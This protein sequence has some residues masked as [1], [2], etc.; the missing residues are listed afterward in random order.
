MD[1]ESAGFPV[2]RRILGNQEDEEEDGMGDGHEVVEKRATSTT[3]FIEEEDMDLLGKGKANNAFAHSPPDQVVEE[4]VRLSRMIK[5]AEVQ[6]TANIEEVLSSHVDQGKPLEVTH[7]VSLSD[8]RKSLQKWAPSAEK[9]Y[10]N[11]VESKRAFRPVKQHELP[12]GCQVVPCKGV[13]TVKPDGKGFRRKT[14]FVACGNHL[15]EG[16]L[17]GS[18]F[19]VY[20]AGLD[21]TSLRTM[22]AYKSKKRS[23]H[24]GVTDIRQAFVLAPWIGKPVA[25]RPPSLAVDLGLAEPDD[26]WLVL[27]SIYGLRESPAAWAAY[28]DGQLKA[29]RW[30]ARLENEEV[31]LRLEQLVSDNQVWRIVRAD[32]KE[33]E[34]LGFLLVYIDD[35]MV[36]GLEPAMRSFFQWLSNTWEC[37]D[38]SVLTEEHPLKFLGMELHLVDGGVE[39]CQEGF[40]RELLRSHQHD[41][42][43]SKTQGPKELM[44]MSAE[45][46]A[47]MLEG[48]P[49][50]DEAKEHLVKD[51]QRR[52]GELLWL[53]SR[54]RPDIQYA[55]AVMSSRITRCPEAVVTIGQ[56]ILDYLNETIHDRI[57][58]A[59]DQEEPQLLQAYTDSSFAPSS[60]KSHGSVAIFYGTCPLA[61]RSSRQPLVSLSTAETELME[62]VEGTVM[63]Y[64]TKCLL[65]ELLGKPLV[66]HLHIDNSAAI[67][68][69]TTAAGSWRTR[70]LRLRA[71]WVKEKMQLKEVSIKHEP[72]VT[73]RADLGTK[74][75]S[76]DRLAQLKE[77]WSVK[78]RRP[79]LVSSLKVMNVKPW[80]KALLF[81]SQVSETL[82]MKE[83]IRAEVPWDLYVVVIILAIAVIGL[84]EGLKHCMSRKKIHLRTL[85]TKAT[86]S[87]DKLTRNELKELQVLMTRDPASLDDDEKIRLVDLKE[88]FDATMPANTSPLPTIP[89]EESATSSTS[90][91]SVFNKQPKCVPRTRDQGV[92]KDPPAFERVPPPPQ[93]VRVY[94]G[95]FHQVEGRDV[96][97]VYENCWGLRHTGPGRKKTVQLCRCCAENNGNRI[98]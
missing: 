2:E 61:W 76:K 31:E 4:H 84:W 49:T 14:R 42:A 79:P 51:A 41:G 27:Q 40:I 11:L 28:R 7:T 10:K 57:R 37:D 18:D 43:R 46:E 55:T 5:K 30:H 20:A 17:T 45:E 89:M 67:S 90:T 34:E 86:R 44:I 29:A 39:V 53:S 33:S 24:M 13:F 32:G 80:M 26:Y 6:Y 65:E 81:I 23:W 66:I 63:A 72:G 96:I 52:V 70:H 47:M 95:P 38:L 93:H 35:L 59:D 16:E 3:A 1:L 60:G 97:H 36:V 69:M 87:S 78:N 73:Q 64:S 74:P 19:D 58:F 91:P 21:A 83:D 15:A 56:R 62:G 98:Y 9:E 82:G 8:V 77:L 75:F 12:A 22:L 68:L 92:Q 54:S 94:E 25:L 71:N 88:L 85:R 50:V 48:T